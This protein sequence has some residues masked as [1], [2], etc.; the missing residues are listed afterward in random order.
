MRVTRRGE[1]PNLVCEV[2]HMMPS[3]VLEMQPLEGDHGSLPPGFV[4]RPESAF[5]D[6]VALAIVAA[7]N[8]VIETV[9][10]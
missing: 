4:D 5:P 10:S 7:Q 2:V 6:A 8:K 1:Y 9:S 3:D